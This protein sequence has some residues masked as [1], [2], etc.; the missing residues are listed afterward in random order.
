MPHGFVFLFVW[1]RL[2]VIVLHRL[3]KPMLVKS[4]LWS[5]LKKMG[6]LDSA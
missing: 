5:W 1:D 2:L 6:P 4:T 3:E